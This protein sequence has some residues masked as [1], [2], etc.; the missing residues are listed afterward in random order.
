MTNRIEKEINR[1]QEFIK[2]ADVI[3]NTS[4]EKIIQQKDPLKVLE[5]S[6]KKPGRPSGSKNK[7]GKLIGLKNEQ[8]KHIHKLWNKGIVHW[9]LDS[10]QMDLYNSYKKALNGFL[11]WICARQIGKTYTVATI[12]IEECLNNPGYQIGYILPLK[13]QARDILKMTMTEILEDCPKN[14]RPRY[15][16]MSNKWIFKNGS[17]IWCAGT[18]AENIESIRGKHFNLVIMDECGSMNKFEYCYQ[19]VLFQ[20]LKHAVKPITLMITTPPITYDHEFN[21]YWDKAEL[22]GRFILRT[23]YDCPRL[24]PARIQQ[25][26]DNYPGGKENV[27][28]RREEMC[29]RI[30][31]LASLVVPEATNER[32]EEI[33]GTWESPPF[34]KKY[35]S[36]DFGVMVFNAFVF[37]Y[38]DF[39]NNMIVIEDEL[40]LKGQDV[41]I[42]MMANH[43]KVKENALWK[44]EKPT[45]RVCDNNLQIIIEFNLTHS[46]PFTATEKHDKP[47]A[48]AKIRNV[49][50]E[51]RIRIHP[52]CVH[53]IS[54][55]K[56]ATWNKQRTDFKKTKDH[57]YD[58]LDA[59][60][61]L[62][63]N[64]DFN[65]NPYPAGW[66][67]Q[68]GMMQSPKAKNQELT[69]F[70]KTIKSMFEVQKRKK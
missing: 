20:T 40:A 22:E 47:S 2:D 18:D 7:G 21:D 16:T 69:S 70:Q 54:H 29:E 45:M 64:I 55:L 12:A 1:L 57:H 24:T 38:Y 50:I 58:M 30:P 62:V 48:I 39:L 56:N 35:T 27:A 13:S 3:Q 11:V 59:L 67:N 31:D 8:L 63:R 17:E 61:Y 68:L 6:K 15:N 28:F 52:R 66:T 34:A 26:I 32:M 33:I 10:N 25:I 44:K 37:G 5:E 65:S 41:T 43:V 42:P 23:I 19:N 60:I 49:V 46:L 36:A 14:L 51:K 53:L 4:P 9:K